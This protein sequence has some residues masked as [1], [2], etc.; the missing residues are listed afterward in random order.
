MVAVVQGNV[1][2]YFSP[3]DCISSSRQDD[4]FTV[5]FNCCSY[6]EFTV[7]LNLLR[8]SRTLS[9]FLVSDSKRQ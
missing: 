7:T 3:D 4:S 2:E 1:H 9:R 6:I 5:H 8:A